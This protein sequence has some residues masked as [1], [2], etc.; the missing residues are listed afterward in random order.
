MPLMLDR[1]RL[2][3]AAAVAGALAALPVAALA[4]P[5]MGDIPLGNKNAPVT[6]IEYASFTCPH[7]GNFARQD[8]PQFKQHYIDTGKVKF[9]LREVYFDKY[10]LWASMVARCGGPKAFYPLAETF[11]TKQ[12]VWLGVPQDQIGDEIAKIGRL[13]GL[14]STQIKK[15]LS[16]QDYAHALIQQYQTNAAKDNV[17][18]TPTFFINGKKHTGEMPYDQFAKLIDAAL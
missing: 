13:N 4:D 1:R 10:G 15:C 17:T 11:L 18:A 7:C 5:V 3:A 12:K 6:V 8:F 16:D 14:S 9:I 2:L